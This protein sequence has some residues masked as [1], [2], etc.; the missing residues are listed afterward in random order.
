MVGR[1]Y[2]SIDPVDMRLEVAMRRTW[3]VL[4][5]GVLAAVVATAIPA[6]AT[7]TYVGPL[8][9]V[10]KIASTV[11]ANGDINPYG[12]VVVPA[13]KGSLV[14]GDVLISNF[15]AKSNQQGTG[16]TI[17][18][19]SPNGHRRLFAHVDAST[20]PGPCPGG[21][22]LT[23]ALAVLRSG[24]VVVGSL[25]TTNGMS[26][27]AKRGCLLVLDSKGMVR[28]TIAGSKI[29]GPWDM[30]WADNGATATLF[31]TNVLNGTVKAHGKAVNK[32]TV[33]RID[34]T[35]QAGQMPAVAS[36]KII[37]SGFAERTDPAALV[38]GPTGLGLGQAGLYVADTVHS[39][40]R[41]IKNPLGRMDSA[42]TGTLVTSGGNLLQ[43]LGLTVTPNGDVLTVNA[44]NGRLVETTP[45]GHQA[46]VKFLDRSGRPPGAGALFGL[47]IAPNGVYFVDDATNRLELLH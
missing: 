11:P 42:D 36:E 34:L 13:S 45:A 38:V 5:S 30:T 29:N 14:K 27:T 37:G 47:A 39:R 15:N 44:A 41:L 32:G 21:V 2:P 16:T 10:S 3:T 24:W 20:L 1:S 9:H 28:E 33:V 7:G 25:P 19:I 18:E 22:G 35:I 31:V 12:T 8:K 6:S 26:A 23:T 46:A 17:V 4:L 40:I 43:P